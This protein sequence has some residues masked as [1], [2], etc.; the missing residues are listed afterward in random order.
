MNV[1]ASLTVLA[2]VVGFVTP[3]SA[4]DRPGDPFGNHTAELNSGTLF[5]TW[6]FLKDQVL[7]DKKEFLFCIEHDPSSCP[8]VS[9][10][11]KIVEE[12]R[13]NQGKALL[14]HLNR[15][16]N[17]MIKGVPA[18]WRGPLEVL[19]MRS[20]DCKSY[21]IAKYAAVRAAGFPRRPR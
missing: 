3:I 16:I 8:E 4:D 21:S 1:A 10:L 7:L 19:K 9:A 17:L 5:A 20:G 18:M 11:M 6:E 2:L 12:A 15:S 13:Q 14:A